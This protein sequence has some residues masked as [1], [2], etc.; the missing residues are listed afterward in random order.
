MFTLVFYFLKTAQ[1]RAEARR[2]YFID[3]QVSLRTR[4]ETKHQTRS[5]IL[6][7]PVLARQLLFISIVCI[8][9][10]VHADFS[11]LCKRQERYVVKVIPSILKI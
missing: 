8:L 1:Y 10:S 4:F 2:S 5:D 7:R 11:L 3:R 9:T 6:L